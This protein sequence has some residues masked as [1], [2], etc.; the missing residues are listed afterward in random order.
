MTMLWGTRFSWSGEMPLD[1]PGLNPVAL[2]RMEPGSQPSGT[3]LDEVTGVDWTYESTGTPIEHGPRNGPYGTRVLING[4]NPSTERGRIRLNYFNGLWPSSGRFLV[5]A[6]MEQRFGM[7][8]NPLINT[9]DTDPI[10]YLSSHVSGPPRMQVYDANGSLVLSTYESNIPFTVHTAHRF[11]GIYVDADAMTGRMIAATRTGDWWLGP[12]RALSGAPNL[13]S[14]AHLD[15]AALAS[16]NYWESVFMD[17]VVVAHPDASFSSEDFARALAG[18]T[19][20]TGQERTAG[21]GNYSAFTVTDTEITG[22]G[23]FSTGAEEVSWDKQPTL[24]DFPPNSTLYRSTDD[25]ATWT[26]T[27]PGNLPTSFTGLLRAEVSLTGGS[28]SGV[29]LVPFEAIEV[30]PNDPVHDPEA[31]TVTVTAQEGV[32]WSQTGTITIPQDGTVEITAT[33]ATDY[34]FPSGAQTEWIFAYTL[35][36]PP[37]IGA[38]PNL[39]LMQGETPVTLPLTFTAMEPYSWIVDAPT[40]AGVSIT[41]SEELEVAATY[42]IGTADA[43]ITLTDQLGRSVSRTFS[44]TVNPIPYEEGPPPRY[45]NAPIILW[46]DDGPVEVLIDPLEAIITKEVNGAHTFEMVVP[47]DHRVAHVLAPERTIEVA[48]ERFRIRRITTVRENRLPV[49]QIYAEARF[50]D[51]ATERQV[52]GREWMQVLPGEVM[53][54]ALEDTDWTLGEVNVGTRRT[55]ETEDSNPLALLRKVQAEHGGDLLFD[56]LQ[57]VVSLVRQSGQDKGVAFFYGAGLHSSKRIVDTTSL[58][59][60]IYA[61]NEDGQTIAPVNGGVPYV[62]DFTWTSEVKTATYDYSAGTSPYTM[63]AWANANLANRSRPDFSYEVTVSDLSRLTEED[64][65]RFDAGDIV[66]VVDHAMQIQETQRVVSLEYNVVKP[67]SSVIT[68]SATLRELGSSSEDDP[69]VLGTGASSSVFD[70]VPYNLLLNGRFDNGTAHWAH[71]G[72]AVVEGDGTG[73]YAVEFGSGTRWIEQTV[74]PDNRDAFAFSMDLTSQ[75]PSGWVP[76]VVVEAEVVYEDGS[77]E[78]IEL[79]L[80]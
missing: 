19:W 1:F 67:W 79:D 6:W 37:T 31:N 53:A 40:L 7:T 74:S 68:L 20:A 39:D 15:L 54:V 75:G 63:L 62:E 78:I 50:Y 55:F 33:P 18:G 30:T 24:P 65:D 71:T 5:G 42:E 2:T 36:G 3:Y 10:V 64:L 25:G 72:A 41:P 17:E 26:V 57:R 59:T 34:T 8:F 28:F 70:L 23:Q 38:I 43:T 16:S 27:D 9:R 73:D 12:E 69:T 45:P 60:R 32:V 61:Q 13:A 49:Y 51:L 47:V 58:V 56:N 21:G 29:E 14:T 22:T 76:D 44:I 46:D 48:G 52:N 35:P 80:E 66:T 4:Q 77:S 11:L